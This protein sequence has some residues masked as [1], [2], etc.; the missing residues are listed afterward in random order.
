MMKS[1][2]VSYLLGMFS[3]LPKFS[4]IHPFGWFVVMVAAFGA[5]SLDLG[6]GARIDVAKPVEFKNFMLRGTR[7]GETISFELKGT[8]RVEGRSG[9]RLELISG[10][11]ALMEMPEAKGVEVTYENGA[12]LLQFERAG[13]IPV[14]VRF[15]AAVK[16]V[17]DGN[18]VRF[19]VVGA[20][21]RPVELIGFGEDEEVELEGATRPVR[22]GESLM[23]HLGHGRG[24]RLIWRPDIPDTSGKLFYA[25]DANIVTTVSPGL[26]RHVHECEVSILQGE[27]DSIDFLIEGDGEITRVEGE[28]LVSWNI[29]PGVGLGPRLLRVRL[30][31]PQ[32]E[33]FRLTVFT[34]SSLSQFPV[35]A[36]VFRLVPVGATRFGGHQLVM[37][38]GAVRLEVSDR[39]GL[40]QINPESLSRLIDGGDGL[41]SGLDLEGVQAFAFRI[42]T[43]LY[44]LA[45]RA[46]N[47]LPEV[48]ASA[49]MVFELRETE[50]VAN[51]GLELE[52]R[53]AP[54]REFS[55]L[56][57]AD[58]S[59]GAIEFAHL[60]D[61]FLTEETDS[62]ARLRLVFSRPLEGRQLLNLRLE[63]NHDWS[64]TKW[65]LPRIVPQDVKSLRGYL[66][67][68]AEPGIRLASDSHAG[69]T[70][71][72][73]AFFPRRDPD[74][75]QAYRIK[76]EDWRV[77]VAVERLPA[78]IR[79]EI[80]HHYSIGEGVVYGSS[81][82]NLHVSGAPV[83]MFRISV[84]ERYENIEFTG[85][86]VRNWEAGP[87]EFMVYLHS[88]VA[89]PYTLLATYDASFEHGGESLPF[90]GAQP[91]DAESE[92]GSVV[93][94]SPYQFG[95]KDERVSP[96]LIRIDVE[97]IPAEYRLLLDSP[98]L[99]AF[100]Y[101]ARPFA[102]ELHLLLFQ[103]GE[104][105]DQLIDFAGFRTEV[106]GGGE[107][108]TVA[109]FLIKSQGTS[110]FRVR[111]PDSARLWWANVDGQ[112]VV[113]VTDREDVLIPLPRDKA[114]GIMTTV[115]MKLAGLPDQDARIFVTPPAAEVP[116][117]LTEW[118]I[119]S[120]S[121]Y[122]LEVSNRNLHARTEGIAPVGITRLQRLITGEG[123]NLHRVLLA[124]ALGFAVAGGL[125]LRRPRSNGPVEAA[126][127]SSPG[128]LRSGAACL[129]GVIS[130]AALAVLAWE[131]LGDSGV[132]RTTWKLSA[133]MVP[134][135]YLEN[136]ELTVRPI[137]V[138]WD[139]VVGSGLLAVGLLLHLVLGRFGGWSGAGGPCSGQVWV[140]RAAVKALPVTL[141][142][143]GLLQLPYGE[144]AL[145]CLTA[146]V[147]MWFVVRPAARAMRLKTLGDSALVSASQAG[148]TLAIAALGLGILPGHEANANYRDFDAGGIAESLKQRVVV[149]EESATVDCV[150]LW[151]AERGESLSILE[152]PGILTRLSES[153]RDFELDRVFENE[154][155]SYIIRA[156]RSG[157]LSVAYSY[158]LPVEEED[159]FSRINLPT[160]P[161]LL[162]EVNI[163]IDQA[164]L[165]LAS[166]DAVMIVEADDQESGTTAARV[167]LTPVRGAR[168]LW[169]PKKRETR[170]E[171]AVVFAE[172]NHLFLPATGVIDGI[173]LFDLRLAQGEVRKLSFHVPEV[174]TISSVSADALMA[175][176]FDPEGRSLRV[177]FGSPRTSDFRVEIRSQSE[178]GGLPYSSKLGMISVDRVVGEV[179]L[180]G[181]ATSSD[182]QLG[183]SM[184]EGLVAI[185]IE[186]FPMDP[187][188]SLGVA[189][190]HL[191]LR[192][193]FRFS[194]PSATLEFEALA[195]E[196]LVR[197]SV[198]QT[199]SLGEDQT[200]LATDLEA[201]ISRS[202]VFSLSFLLPNQFEVETITGSA[203]SH[204]TESGS[205]AEKV[206]T[207]HTTGKII[208]K[209]DFHINLIGPGVGTDQLLRAPRLVL[210]ESEKHRG[211]FFIVP[212][213]GMR[214]DIADRHGLTQVDPREAGVKRHGVQVFRLLRN[215]W[216]LGFEVEKIDPWIEVVSLQDATIREGLI[217]MRG[218]LDY[219]IEN[220][221]IKTLQLWIPTN[222][223]GVRFAGKF[224]EESQAVSDGAGS[225]SVA[226]RRRVIGD[227]RL[228][229][230]F[231]VV[232]RGDDFPETLD[233][234]RAHDASLQRG[235][236]ALRSVGRL[237]LR[238]KHP[239]ALQPLHWEAIPRNLLPDA[240]EPATL[241]FRALT[242]DFVLPLEVLRH[243]TAEV[244]P[245]RVTGA[246]LTSLVSDAGAVLTVARISLHPG[247]KRHLR[248]RIPSDAHFW[249]AFVND[250]SALPWRDRNDVLIPLGERLESG[251]A[252]TVEFVYAS[253]GDLHFGGE[254]EVPL[255][256]PRFDL[257]LENIA[258]RVYLP[259]HLRLAD[260]GGDLTMKREDRAYPDAYRFNLEAY[261]NGER[262][263][264]AAK[265][266][267]AE[268]MLTTG[269]DL[270]NEGNQRAARNALKSAY[271]LSRH[272]EAFNEDARVQLNNL[273]TN[274]ALVGLAMRRDRLQRQFAPDSKGS[275]MGPRG[276][277]DPMNFTPQQAQAIMGGIPAEE[278]D[279]LTRLAERIVRQHT[280]VIDSPDAIRASLPLQGREY[281]FTRNLQVEL[282]RD[283]G[284]V[285]QTR[286]R[287]DW[288]GRWT[289]SLFAAVL[290]FVAVAGVQRR[291]WVVK[292]EKRE[293]EVESCE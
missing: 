13:S 292:S 265:I 95:L 136:I 243:Q 104:R 195:I 29:L 52:I 35:V 159:S 127:V 97:E 247:D 30:N 126:S 275:A 105:V 111:I 24:F 209:H 146:T 131:G 241:A 237:E 21:I 235:Y 253:S 285:L 140:S 198:R 227:Y 268:E 163:L 129:F 280:S 248:I 230:S 78:S 249:Y 269:N 229:V 259:E 85:K 133:T 225:W 71:L 49:L 114:P 84:P 66:A 58:Y 152:F 175:W 178:S 135:D 274:Q 273:L 244:L 161:A 72:A 115:E 168:I 22:N 51:V 67:V 119:I 109:R 177:D 264:L 170:L 271:S 110:H 231:Q 172:A 145:L 188:S 210:R 208:G 65:S 14:N 224:I 50:T 154:R 73:T 283:L 96:E 82:M 53:E 74:L 277:A 102:V 83:T 270:A 123:G 160:V 184:G 39:A 173:H 199:L 31:P 149:N 86:D 267:R 125:C 60:S 46:D 98:V 25:V 34:R 55:L 162:S 37:N 70:E 240:I 40:S 87:E 15:R 89:G 9:G 234:I 287:L 272:D 286:R 10:S 278:G 189:S 42:S 193:A 90:S 11:V 293:W 290:I 121:G 232:V 155:A 57:P 187:L 19:G 26:M 101:A 226:L 201:T 113:P 63:K 196:P 88:P 4:G 204:W 38:E 1:R 174:F 5:G 192:R 117:L 194:D 221:G 81:L 215:D 108:L 197:S 245:A 255:V 212:E 214:L 223:T 112:K 238:V 183:S 262:T 228:E 279:G 266:Q 132:D 48:T 206:I 220:A 130:L 151:D 258:W 158:N 216:N 156:K 276:D 167:I 17:G 190:R 3:G 185:N 12:Y 56:V 91:L 284:L 261:L 23:A 69:V 142:L 100:Q 233:G 288:S 27:M 28:G 120:E 254:T 99:T 116:A 164:D 80:F 207:L 138:G 41:E 180:V 16:R 213:E 182:V 76:G 77:S 128:Y 59:I 44:R 144:I 166:E 153:D 2:R 137:L 218:V 186:D 263:Q 64:G 148:S 157:R 203:L 191:S 43:P 165:E 205:D 200:V 250:H 256:G 291:V 75:Q 61:Y 47:V 8:A 260:Y 93:V 6:A 36:E 246:D 124:V 118:E 54:L 122:F 92:Q 147:V 202:G 281:T 251:F 134:P 106:S 217:E 236:F 107:T 242:P 239:S 179:G 141:I 282:W 68:K 20:S 252:S 7:E 222:A 150:M 62:E 45:M 211:V 171:S 257:P 33:D 219:K 94:E 176:R 103:Q 18:E 143:S 169:Q 32:K 139:F 289:L 79:A 181:I